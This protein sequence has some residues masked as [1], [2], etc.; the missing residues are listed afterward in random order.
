MRRCV[1]CVGCLLLSL[2]LVL[3]C[4]GSVAPP[5]PVYPV[6][7]TVKYNGQPVVGADVTFYNAEAGR[8]AFGRTNEDG[9]YQL[10]TFSSNDGAV[11][12]KQVVTILKVEPPPP[13]VSEPSVESQDYVP[14]GIGQDIAPVKP[15]SGIPEKYGKAETS[16]LIAVV[17]ADAPNKIDF[18]LKD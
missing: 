15:K 10:S 17:N 13:V 11:A 12:G 3:G 4:G 7:G 16:G 1:G 8:S 14:P 5:A 2:P 6:S 18:D 9:E